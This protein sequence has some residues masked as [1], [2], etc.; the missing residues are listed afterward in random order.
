MELLP[1]LFKRK[2]NDNHVGL[3]LG[4]CNAHLNFLLHR[5]QL[6]RTVDDQG[7]YRYKSVDETL[8]MRLR[9]HRPSVDDQAPIQV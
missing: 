4:E 9:K 6:E 8:T 7:C 3:A 5:G 2:L 1:V